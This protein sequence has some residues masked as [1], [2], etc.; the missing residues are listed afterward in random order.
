MARCLVTG[1]AGF[2]GSH[3]TGRLLELGHEVTVLDD[4]STGRIENLDHV[5]DHP[6]FKFR[7]ASIT[8]PVALAD[9]VPG[10]RRGLPHGGGGR[11]A[12]C[13]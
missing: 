7:Q 3:L 8:D 9:V 10:N 11:C 12:A 4:L 2:I 5:K 13:C 1:G 6:N